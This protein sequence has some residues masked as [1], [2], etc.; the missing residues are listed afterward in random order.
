MLLTPFRSPQYLLGLC[1]RDGE[2]APVNNRMARLWFM[3]AA[4]QGHKDAAKALKEYG[5]EIKGR[6]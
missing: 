1:Y 6:A 5:S 2:G 4:K 3:K